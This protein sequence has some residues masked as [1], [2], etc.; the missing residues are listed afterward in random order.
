[1]RGG[2]VSSMDADGAALTSLQDELFN[3]H[4][5]TNSDFGIDVMA[6]FQLIYSLIGMTNCEEYV[7][8]MINWLTLMPIQLQNG[9]IEQCIQQQQQQQQPPDD[10][11]TVLTAIGQHMN[12]PNDDERYTIYN[13]PIFLSNAIDWLEAIPPHLLQYETIAHSVE[14]ICLIFDEIIDTCQ[15]FKLHIEA[16]T[17]YNFRLHG[18]QLKIPASQAHCSKFKLYNV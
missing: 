10:C 7:C 17:L 8:D 4:T 13:L 18:L 15:R 9:K 12:V 5:V 2:V 6:Y 14:K 3:Y 11:E 1:M 16:D